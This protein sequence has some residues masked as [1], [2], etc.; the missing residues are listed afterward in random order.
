VA[1]TAAL[2]ASPLLAQDPPPANAVGIVFDSIRGRP[3]AGARVRIDTTALFATT[4]ADGRFV[5][6]G[7][8]AGPHEL[9]VEHPVL[10]TLGI[11]LRSQLLMFAAGSTSA[12]ELGTPSAGRIVEIVCAPAWRARGP[13]ALVG[14]VREADSGRPA[15]GAKVSLVW[16]EVS[17]SDNLRRVPRVREA[18][19]GPDGIYRICGLPEGLEG[20]IQVIR[21][22]LTSGDVIVAFG[23]ELLAARS[24]SIAA[25]GAVAVA[26][27]DSG[28]TRGGTVLGTARLTGRVV[29]KM[30]APLPNA[31][32]QVEGTTRATQTRASGEFLL[33]SLP[34]GTQ[35][36][37]VRLLGYAP[38]EAAVELSSQEPRSVT[39]RME[40]FVPVLE[41]VR[42]SAQRERALEDVGFARRKRS[43]FGTYMD[44]D[45]I[46]SRNAQYFSDVMRSMP[47]LRVASDGQGRQMIQ[48]AR[49][50]MGG[51]VMIWVD[52]TMWQQMEPGD[53]DDFVKPHE[54]GAIEVYSPTNTPAEFQS[55]GGGSC[56]T[57]VAWTQRKLEQ[58]RRR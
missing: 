38:A 2:W 48:N 52:G 30:G 16:Y 22:P 4:D 9:R 8:P 20:R 32:V 34:P 26:G 28:G 7:I 29:N 23:E 54:L 51:C 45:D 15:T 43:G 24:M 21:G 55:R 13:A 40:D 31:R 58:R 42:V 39:I 36:V 11:D 5:I 33:D 19:V 6:Q 1:A 37:A 10:D 46:K 49:D 17:L 12:H 47:H 14:R 56:A 25:P 3:L 18:V 41:A 27:P 53:I 50:P 35:S 44:I 57:I